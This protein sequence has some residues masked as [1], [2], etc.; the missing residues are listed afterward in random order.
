[1]VA[2][3]HGAILLIDST[4]FRLSS[5][6]PIVPLESFGILITNQDAPKEDLVRIKDMEI[7]VH[8]AS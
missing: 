5:L 4:T 3:A 2:S 7:E 1:M 6:T 8:I